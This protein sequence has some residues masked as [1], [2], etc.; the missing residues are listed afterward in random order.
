MVV[1]PSISGRLSASV[2]WPTAF[3]GQDNSESSAKSKRADQ[4]RHH[5]LARRDPAPE[6]TASLKPLVKLSA[7]RI[8]QT[9]TAFP[10]GFPF[11][12]GRTR[13]SRLVIPEAWATTSIRYFWG[14]IPLRQ[15]DSR[16]M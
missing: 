13:I 2:V 15:L 1:Q 12:P 8:L 9:T 7:R 3:G 16:R 6:L 4:A 5:P 11:M 14:Q 10:V